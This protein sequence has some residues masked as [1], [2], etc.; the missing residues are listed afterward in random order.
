[1]AKRQVKNEYI[2]VVFKF[3]FSEEMLRFIVKM[4]RL[5]VKMHTFLVKMLIEF[6]KACVNNPFLLSFS[7]QQLVTNTCLS[8]LKKANQLRYLSQFASIGLS[9]VMSHFPC[10]KKLQLVLLEGL[11]NLLSFTTENPIPLSASPM[12]NLLL[13]SME[14]MYKMNKEEGSSDISI[15]AQRVVDDVIGDVDDNLMESM[16]KDALLALLP[17]GDDMDCKENV[18]TSRSGMLMGK[19]MVN[20]LCAIDEESEQFLECKEIESRTLDVDDDHVDGDGANAVDSV[21]LDSVDDDGE[22]STISTVSVP[23]SVGSDD[24]D[25]DFDVISEDELDCN[26]KQNY[27]AY[28]MEQTEAHRVLEKW[29][30]EADQDR[31]VAHLAQQIYKKYFNVPFQF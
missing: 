24:D 2:L 26:S 10:D 25:I 17:T 16:S 29:Y 19:K 23:D 3:R 30:Y 14:W 13:S 20:R 27:V 31:D 1:M 28:I 22:C 5:L 18:A 6:L 4:F 21:D 9:R 12:A 8:I 15:A 11:D 7:L